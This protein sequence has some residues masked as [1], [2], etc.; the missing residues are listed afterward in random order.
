MT[1]GEGNQNE[2]NATKQTKQTDAGLFSRDEADNGRA[3][4]TRAYASVY[5]LACGGYYPP[6]GG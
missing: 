5:A 6:K 2:T 1:E 4:Y 3:F